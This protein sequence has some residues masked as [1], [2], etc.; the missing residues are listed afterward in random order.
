[1][2]PN[3]AAFDAFKKGEVYSFEVKKGKTGGV[4]YYEQS[5]SRPDLVL[6]DF[7]K[8]LHPELM[9]DYEFTYATKIQ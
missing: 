5:P 1:M 2:N 4:I 7:I 6:K 3:Y 8:I 9:Q